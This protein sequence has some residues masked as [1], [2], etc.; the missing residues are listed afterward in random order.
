MPEKAFLVRMFVDHCVL[1]KENTRLEKVLLVVTAHAFRIQDAYNSLLDS[2]TAAEEA[3]RDDEVV[4]DRDF[5]L[6]ELLRLE[7]NLD[8]ADEIGRR[9]LE[10]FVRTCVISVHVICPSAELC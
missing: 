1:T 5:I 4:D 3:G 9:R 6:A 8:Y 2:L 7:L 10:Q